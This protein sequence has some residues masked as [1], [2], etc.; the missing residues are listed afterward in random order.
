M[1]RTHPTARLLASLIIAILC[2]PWSSFHGI[3]L[4]QN[5][6]AVGVPE[7]GTGTLYR[8]L[9]GKQLPLPCARMDIDLTVTGVMVHGEVT[10][11]FFNPMDET[12]E[13]IYVFPL[14]DRAAVSHMEMRIGDRRIIA[15]VQ[16]RKEA[17]RTYDRA[18][19]SG[20]RAALLD[21][22]RPNLFRISAAN[23]G[24]RESI[25]VLLHYNEELIPIDGLYRLNFPLTFTP[26]FIPYEQGEG[27]EWPIPSG[28]RTS[29][30]VRSTV[31]DAARITPPFIRTDDVRGMRARVRVAVKSGVDLRDLESPSHDIRITRD[32]GR[33]LVNTEE[34][35]VPTDRDFIL[36]WRLAPGEELQAALLTE[37]REDDTYGLLLLVPPVAG[38]DAANG[39][40]TETLYVVDISGSMQGPSIDQAR[41]ALLVALDRMRPGDR[42]NLMAFNNSSTLFRRDMQ[43]A[44]DRGARE[45]ARHWVQGLKAD[46]GPMILPALQRAMA[47]MSSADTLHARRIVLLTD[48]AVG[49]DQALLTEVSRGLG[50]VRLHVLGIGRAPNQYLA[51]K[52][53]MVGGGLIAFVADLR[54]AENEVDRFLARINRPVLTDLRLAG[55]GMATW[56]LYPPRLPDLYSG[57]PLVVWFRVPSSAADR[58][59]DPADLR[60]ITLRGRVGGGDFSLQIPAPDVSRRETGI[61]VRCARARIASLTDRIIDGAPKDAIKAQVIPIAK[62]F[63]LVTQCTSMVAVEEKPSATGVCRTV[64]MPNTLPS[65]SHLLGLPSGA[66]SGPLRAAAGLV[67]GSV[68]L[69]LLIGYW[70]LRRTR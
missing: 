18:R 29:R 32:D 58:N 33:H 55:R 43:S 2:L 28:E 14:P 4:A 46:N 24:P 65:G 39:H 31:P 47:L 51:R 45:A 16:E 19:Q 26:R 59:V 69:L 67:L 48:A 49:N 61:A 36:T 53:A 62:A 52:L 68:G 38:Q 34:E 21:Q 56:E 8:S 30:W 12:I 17:A 11:E 9:P 25:E 40:L 50:A 42:F 13:V 70:H 35:L 7:F 1:K 54:G 41:E 23:I 5:H 63:N 15:K 64:R 3:A 57:E 66:T 6:P 22:D 20:R 37:E 10:Q 60:S 27:C 44:D